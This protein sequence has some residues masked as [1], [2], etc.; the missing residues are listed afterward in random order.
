MRPDTR[1]LVKAAFATTLGMLSV[2]LAGFTDAR[3]QNPFPAPIFP[4]PG[5]VVPPADQQCIL[6]G[7]RLDLQC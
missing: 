2:A 4:P 5:F 6:G 7:N 1:T 3:A